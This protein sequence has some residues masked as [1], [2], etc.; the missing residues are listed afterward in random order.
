MIDEGY[1]KFQSHWQ[2]TPPLDLA[3]IEELIYWRE[4]LFAAGLIGQ[5][6]DI[7]I[8]YGNISMRVDTA[9]LFVISGTQTGHLEHLDRRHFAL[10][11]DCD[12]AA[13]SV[14]SSGPAEPSSEAM[15][16][17]A[18][19]RLDGAIRAVVHVH[20]TPLWLGLR[21]VLPTTSEDADYGTPRM[22]MEFE[23]LYR[24]SGFA[25]A[26]IAVMAGHEGGLISTGH[27]MQEATN[28]ILAIHDT[29]MSK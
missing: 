10:V 5:Y 1:I 19:Y 6:K 8:G 20:S 28:R 25:A 27:N 21:N 15:T 17:A 7:G 2:H 12:P 24:E 3:E 23:R 11:T 14:T 29:F 16:H 26:G 18:L 4:P 22:V 9:G 13:N